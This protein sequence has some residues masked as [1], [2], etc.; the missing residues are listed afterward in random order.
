M[1]IIRVSRTVWE[2]TMIYLRCLVANRPLLLL[3]LL[4]I[5]LWARAI[6]LVVYG[7]GSQLSQLFLYIT[8]YGIFWSTLM[9][10]LLL[11]WTLKFHQKYTEKM[12]V[13]QRQSRRVPAP[14]D[15][16]AVCRTTAHRLAYR[17]HERVLTNHPYRT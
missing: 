2:N 6:Q 12:R 8:L 9:S 5:G 14:L 7:D 3:V 4:A 1:R 10:A 15:K 13:G 11:R 17:D 16:E